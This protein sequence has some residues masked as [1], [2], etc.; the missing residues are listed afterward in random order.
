MKLEHRIQNSFLMHQHL[1]AAF[2]DIEKVCD[3]AWGYSSLV[4]SSWLASSV[5]FELPSGSS[6]PYLSQ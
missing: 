3:T 1:V 6:L 5:S 4:E 2:Y